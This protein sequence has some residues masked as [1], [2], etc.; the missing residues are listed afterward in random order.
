MK[1]PLSKTAIVTGLN[2]TLAPKMADVLLE[3]GYEVV[4]WDRKR[5][6]LEN[7]SKINDFLDEQQPELLCHLAMGD[8]NWAQKLAIE[9]FNRNIKFLFTST[10]M[11]FNH[12]PDG[13][14][15]VSDQRTALDDY[16]R[17]KVEC[18][19]RIIDCNPNAVIARIGWQIDWN[20]VGNN[21]FCQLTNNHQ[22][23]G[24]IEASDKWIPACSMMSDTCRA[25]FGLLKGGHRGVFHV[26]SNSY[27]KLNF[28][29][30]V[31]KIS[32]KHQ[33]GWNIKVTS[34]YV[35]DQRLLDPRVKIPNISNHL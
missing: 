35:H 34:N 28:A 19:D 31:Y 7:I 10:A 27:D 25:M 17:G 14:H 6:P 5:V 11:V 29:E 9:T 23:D 16:G 15:E 4:A 33:L 12:E 30:L 1:K 24:F 8:K 20:V 18:E 22:R 13:P 32:A 26:D 2:G 21:M 3:N